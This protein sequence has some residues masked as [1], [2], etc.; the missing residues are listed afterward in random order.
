MK[1]RRGFCDL[2]V[3]PTSKTS[4]VN[5]LTTLV[6]RKHNFYAFT[7]WNL[8]CD[9]QVMFSL[10]YC[11][12]NHQDMFVCF[13]FGFLVGYRTVAI[14][15]IVEES[16]FVQDKK[17]KRKADKDVISPI[18]PPMELDDIPQVLFFLSLII[19]ENFLITETCFR[20]GSFFPQVIKNSL[21]ILQRIT[22]YFSTSDNA[23]KMVSCAS[24][25]FFLNHLLKMDS[26]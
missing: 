24:F 3:S 18:P 6:E 10:N 9:F 5:I 12:I 7:S 17:K 26:Y 20:T 11:P 23:H 14:N 1:H 15:Q 8:T 4:L 22:V 16:A 19:I 2:S 13:L 21:Q 25:F